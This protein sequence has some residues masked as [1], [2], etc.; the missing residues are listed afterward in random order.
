MQTSYCLNILINIIS[1]LHTRI[2]VPAFTKTS[3][4]RTRLTIINF[5]RIMEI[6]A[7]TIEFHTEFVRYFC[8]SIIRHYLY[9]SSSTHHERKCQ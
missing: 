6:A 9:A 3:I 7:Y 4:V 2:I 5:I 8:T 1:K